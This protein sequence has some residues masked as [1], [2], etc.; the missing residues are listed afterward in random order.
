[1]S[2]K[3]FVY[4]GGDG[5]VS[6]S[7]PCVKI[8]LALR[9]LGLPYEV[10]V[11]TSGK[12]AAEKSPTGRLPSLQRDNETIAESCRILDL[13]E[14][15]YPDA[16]LWLREGVE[17]EIDYLWDRV[18]NDH[19]YWQGFFMRWVHEPTS[20]AFLSAMLEPAPAMIRFLVPWILPRTMRKRAMAVGVGNRKV[21]DVVATIAADYARA[22]TGIG[23]GPFLQERSTPARGDLAIASTVAQ[24]GYRDTLPQVMEIVRANPVLVDHS[25][26]VFQA[27]GAEVPRWLQA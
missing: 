10:I 12:Q 11:L 24:A 4:P 21:E 7:P 9:R 16:D 26:A 22:A 23:S 3:L 8:D 1:M 15:D 17:R 19:L 6:V 5:L 2:M 27:C 20:R 25:V 13:L 14:R 18:F